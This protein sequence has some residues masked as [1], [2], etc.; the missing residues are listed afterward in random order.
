MEWTTGGDLAVARTS[1]RYQGNYGMRL[2][3][4]VAQEEQSQREA[5]AYTNF[6]V[7]PTMSK[8]VLKFKYRMYVNDIIDYSDFF[9]AV[10]DGVGLNH[11]ETVLRD[12]Y[13]P[14]NPGEP[15]S[16]GQDLGW[17]TA[18]FD[19]T[20]YKGQHIRVNFSNRN[21]WPMK[22]WGIWTDIDDVMVWDEGPLPYI[23]PYRID[24]PMIFNRSCDQRG[25]G[26][27]AEENIIMR[28]LTPNGE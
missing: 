20:K 3:Q 24:L 22:S 1:N 12:G 6:Y 21:L 17:R 10:Q 13:N 4:P 23:G 11:L 7:D 27:T 25:I 5:W 15:P 26:I 2:G 19:L 18:S 28:P 14:C 16:A 8:P 9:V